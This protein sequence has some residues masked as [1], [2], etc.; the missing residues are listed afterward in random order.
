MQLNHT[1]AFPREKRLWY[2]SEGLYD[3]SHFF[4]WNSNQVLRFNKINTFTA[5]TRTFSCNEV[6][7]FVLFHFVFE[8]TEAW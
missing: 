4:M 5:I 1:I 8:T 6:F 7:F 2:R 3:T